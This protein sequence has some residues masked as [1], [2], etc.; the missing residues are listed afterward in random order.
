MFW[1]WKQACGD[2][3]NG[4]G[5]TGN[6]LETV[7]CAT[8]RDLPRDPV[9]AAELSRAY[10]RAVPGVL[11]ALS[12][13]P[14]TGTAPRALTLEGTAGSGSCRLDLWVPGDVRPSP[15]V[16]NITDLTLRQ[17]PGGWR[18]GGCATGPYRLTL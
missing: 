1:V 5:P 18:I 17:V 9:K 8:G 10:P 16:R 14:A 11:T 4:I 6:G 7:D 2:P 3:Q 13:S 15:L 12:S